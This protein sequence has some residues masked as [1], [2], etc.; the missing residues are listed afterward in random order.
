MPRDLPI[1]NERLLVLF[2]ADYQLRDLY[3]PNVGK[4]NH[5]G[6][7]AFRLGV[8]V[9]GSF[10]WVGAAQ[11]WKID[12]RYETDALVTQVTLRHEELG[13]ELSCADCVDFHETLL[14]RKFVVRNL[15]DEAREVRLFFHHDFRIS[16][17]DVGDTAAFDPTTRALVHYKG[18]R[19]FL[20]NL[21]VDG[22]VGVS[23]FATGQKGHGKDGTWRDAEDGVLGMNA[24]A[25]GAVDSVISGRLVVPEK[26][27]N[28]LYYW[29]VCAK[30][31]ERQLGRRRGRSTPRSWRGDPRPSSA[32][33][34]P[35]GSCGSTRSRTTSP[36]SPPS[37][38]DLYRRSLLVVRTQIDNGGG[39]IAA[40]DSDIMQF[41]RDT[42]SYMWPRDGALVAHAL[43]LRR[44][45]RAGAPLLRV[46]RRCHHAGG[47][48]PAQ[49]Q[50]RRLARLVL[51]S[52]VRAAGAWGRRTGADAA[53]DPGGRDRAGAVGD[54]ARTTSATATSTR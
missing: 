38:V 54:V 46:L 4:E 24:I 16:E 14:L 13:L 5:A 32:A 28:T 33:R 9:G 40:N 26:G 53:P 30:K 50:P 49:V 6:G 17:S 31:S 29:L 21:K 45:S 22:K 34:A 3:Y 43:D 44:L 8:W 25:Q 20:A 18:Y 47:L 10:A 48:S 41:A 19:Y 37:I 51:A 36:I 27:D 52:L 12:R 1:G 2:D 15:R 11:G 7:Y 42:Y 39:I 23:S 35:T